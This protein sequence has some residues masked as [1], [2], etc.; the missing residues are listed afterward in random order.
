MQR[1]IH[2]SII[3]DSATY[4][5]SNEVLQF[6][7]APHTFRMLSREQ[8]NQRINILD[9]THKMKGP[10]TPALNEASGAFSSNTVSPSPEVIT[11]DYNWISWFPTIRYNRLAVLF[12]TN[13]EKGSWY[14]EGERWY[15]A[16]PWTN[17]NKNCNLLFGQVE[18]TLRLSQRCKFP[19]SMSWV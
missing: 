1:N 16:I 8:Q 17:G 15:C 9:S 6:G 5:L 4:L 3:G 11:I 2:R 14:F 12:G 10:A 19:M 13:M 18:P 7:L